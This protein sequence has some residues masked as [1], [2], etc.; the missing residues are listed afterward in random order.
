[1]NREKVISVLERMTTI[2]GDGFTSEK[3]EEAWAELYRKP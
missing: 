3:I 2:L 1:M